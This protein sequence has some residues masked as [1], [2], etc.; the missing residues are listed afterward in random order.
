MDSQTPKKLY[1]Y[2]PFGINTLNMLAA[3][4]IYFSSPDSFNDPLDCRPEI[5]IDLDNDLLEEVLN[6]LRN[7]KPHLQLKSYTRMSRENNDGM[8]SHSVRRLSLKQSLTINLHDKMCDK[9]IVSLAESWQ[10]PLMWS[11]YADQHRGMCFEYD[12]TKSDLIPPKKIDYDGKRCIKASDLLEFLNGSESAR[13][14]IEHTFFFTKASQWRYENEWRIVADY[15][16]EAP[17]PFKLTSI[18][19]GM[20]CELVAASAVM[21]LIKSRRISFYWAYPREDQFVLERVPIDI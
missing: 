19:F 1:K 12:I 14:K 20:R 8:D 5:E 15:Q 9:G 2:R 21:N 3:P 6:R 4:S 10:C 17:L 7:Y 13:D 11:H 16:G 18:Y